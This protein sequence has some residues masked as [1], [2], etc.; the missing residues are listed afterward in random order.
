MARLQSRLG[1]EIT[2]VSHRTDS[3]I[4]APDRRSAAAERVNSSS[5]WLA[6]CL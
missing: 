3:A 4:A 1:A 6:L 5:V 2:N